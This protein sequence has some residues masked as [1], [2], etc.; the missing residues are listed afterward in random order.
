MLS[1][2]QNRHFQFCEETFEQQKEL[3]FLW[4]LHHKEEQKAEMEKAMVRD[5]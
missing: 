2:R 1:H 3:L 4:L 5:G